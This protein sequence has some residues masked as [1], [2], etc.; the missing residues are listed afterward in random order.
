MAEKVASQV[1]FEIGQIKQ[2][3]GTYSDLLQRVQKRTPDLVEIA[4]I[5]S[6]LH[7]FYN[8]LEKI[9]LSIAKGLDQQAPIGFQWHRDLLVQMTQETA[10]RGRVMSTELARKLADSG[11]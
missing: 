6:V 7:C 3:V 8:G 5:G 9:F 11:I 1:A 10:T 2:L 4:A